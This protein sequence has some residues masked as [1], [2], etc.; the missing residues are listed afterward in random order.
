MM[1]MMKILSADG[2]A[3]NERPRRIISEFHCSGRHHQNLYSFTPADCTAVLVLVLLV[4]MPTTSEHAQRG[5]D[6]YHH[7]END[8]DDDDHKPKHHQKYV[9]NIDN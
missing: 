3:S 8:G 9:N 7:H 6:Y 2:E 5:D 4:I 1:M